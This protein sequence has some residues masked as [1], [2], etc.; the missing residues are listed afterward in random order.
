MKTFLAFL[1]EALFSDPALKRAAA[2]IFKTNFKLCEISSSHSG[3]YE[4]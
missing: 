3:E 4:V 1:L 2:E